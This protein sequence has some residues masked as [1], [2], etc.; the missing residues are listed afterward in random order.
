[1]D[2]QTLK[3]QHPIMATSEGNVWGRWRCAE[4][5]CFE[6]CGAVGRLHW[7]R[8]AAAPLRAINWLILVS[9]SHPE[10]GQPAYFGVLAE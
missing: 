2:W 4:L 5:V 3:A 10:A 9:K 1:M 7:L 6:A 8:L